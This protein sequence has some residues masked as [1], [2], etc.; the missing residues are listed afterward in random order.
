[1][2]EVVNNKMIAD[3]VAQL[4]SMNIIAGELDR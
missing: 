3:A 1:M 2:N 4:G